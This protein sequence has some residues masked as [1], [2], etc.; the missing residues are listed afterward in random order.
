MI[1]YQSYL[2]ELWKEL[3]FQSSKS[4]AS[5]GRPVFQKYF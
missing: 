1:T 5:S 2:F 3:V 4:R